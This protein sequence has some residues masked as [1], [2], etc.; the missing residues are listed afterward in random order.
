MKKFGDKATCH[1]AFSFKLTFIPCLSSFCSCYIGVRLSMYS[2]S[3]TT[4]FSIKIFFHQSKKT[5]A[6]RYT[7]LLST[8]VS[9]M[10]Q[11]AFP[12]CRFFLNK[13]DGRRVIFLFLLCSHMSS[14]CMCIYLW[15]EEESAFDRLFRLSL[16]IPV[17]VCVKVDLWK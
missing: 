17:C 10:A 2:M 6:Y 12:L 7:R 3:Q 14:P 11:W 15:L 4:F 1:L 13:T 5:Y 8:N 9:F 16:C